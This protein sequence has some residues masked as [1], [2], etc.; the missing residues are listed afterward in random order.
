LA[1]PELTPE[2]LLSAYSI[3]LFP[4]A[5]SSDDPFLHWLDPD[6]RGAALLKDFRVPRRLRKT[7]RKRPFEIRINTAFKATMEYCAQST[8]DRP[9]T[10]I[11]DTIIQLY[12]ELHYQGQA[13]SVECW[14]DNRL[15]GGL[16]GVSLGTAF[17]GESMFSRQTDASKIALV[18]LVILLLKGGY[19]LLDC[20]FWT[21]HLS[22]FGIQ[23]MERKDYHQLLQQAMGSTGQFS[24]EV[25]PVDIS[26]FLQRTIQTS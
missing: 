19:T 12:T 13:H 6:I 25:S 1:E 26:D 24:N 5:E 14:Q 4:M 16:Y 8:N 18:S 9:D 22:Q 23:Q 15:V 21:E 20:Q 7:I 3:G 10:W 2:L 17:F 11:N